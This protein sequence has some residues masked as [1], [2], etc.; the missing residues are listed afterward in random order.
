MTQPIYNAHMDGTSAD[1]Q[2]MHGNQDAN[3]TGK[4]VYSRKGASAEGH[5]RLIDRKRNG[6]GAAGNY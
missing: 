5:K 2:M 6:N 1:H 4:N 3:M